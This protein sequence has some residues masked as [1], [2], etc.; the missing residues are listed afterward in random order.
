MAIPAFSTH[1]SFADSAAVLDEEAALAE[2]EIVNAFGKPSSELFDKFDPVA[3]ASASLALAH[4][5]QLK[6][7]EKVIVKILRPNIIESL[8]DDLAILFL[9]AKLV[10]GYSKESKRLRPL[11]VVTDYQ[12]TVLNE[13]D[14]MREA[15]NCA[16]IGRN[17]QGSNIIKVPK[18]YWD[19]CRQNILVQERI[20]GIPINDIE[21]LEA[22][23]IE[24]DERKRVKTDN[25]FK[26]NINNIYAIGDVVRG[27]MLAHKAEDEGIAVAENIAGQ[28]GHVNY[29]TI[30]AIVYTNPEV[31][32]VGKTENQLKEAKVDYN[33]F[34]VSKFCSMSIPIPN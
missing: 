4:S 33:E 11:E 22:A 25:T 10:D 2:L 3:F 20:F 32:S 18:I 30:P 21:A 8:E 5:A 27:A 9:L 13:L 34:F 16:Q 26:T 14:L 23:G 12:K 29:D 19:F 17:W 6:T 28:S 31:A 24:L 15:A 7:G 1:M